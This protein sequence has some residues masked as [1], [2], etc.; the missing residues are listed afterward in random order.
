[1]RHMGFI[2]EKGIQCSGGLGS[3]YGVIIY[4]IALIQFSYREIS[5]TG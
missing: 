3:N 4:G 1:M 2:D 5:V